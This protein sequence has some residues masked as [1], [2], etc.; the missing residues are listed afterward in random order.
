MQLNMISQ[1]ALKVTIKRQEPSDFNYSSKHKL[2]DIYLLNRK[3][4]KQ[5]LVEKKL[6]WYFRWSK[7]D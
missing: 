5:R 2:H 1:I 3:L 7:N 4:V 6:D